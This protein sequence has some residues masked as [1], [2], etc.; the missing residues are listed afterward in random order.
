MRSLRTGYEGHIR[1]DK[2]IMP[3]AECNDNCCK[4]FFVGDPRANQTTQLASIHSMF[5]RSHNMFAD[6]HR[7]K[8]PKLSDEELFN[9]ARALNIDIFCSIIF[10][11]WLPLFIGNFQIFSI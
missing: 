11:Y 8:Y 5:S 1:L 4:F 7:L 3:G 2:G 9:L 10:N 6:L